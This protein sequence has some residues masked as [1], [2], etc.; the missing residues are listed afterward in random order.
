QKRE[1]KLTKEL[2]AYELCKIILTRLFGSGYTWVTF[3]DACN[4]RSLQDHVGVVH[5]SNLCTEI[6]LNTSKEE[7][8]VCN[9][10]SINLSK[11]II[12]DKLDEEL[13]QKTIMTAMRMLDNVIDLNYYLT[14]ET[15]NSN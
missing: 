7:I 14:D 5:C 12:N 13:F 10:G 3:K 2:K 9:L 8:A 6:T 1:I 15:E 4:I 11:H